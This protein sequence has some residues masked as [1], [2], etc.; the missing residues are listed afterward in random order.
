MSDETDLANGTTESWKTGPD[1]ASVGR[2]PEQTR[3]SILNA[4][5]TEFA[6]RGL[7]GGRTDRIAANAGVAKRMIFH[8]FGS[9][10]GLFQ[11]VLETNYARIRSAEAK[12]ELSSQVPM[13]A[14]AELIEFSFDWFLSHPEFIPLLNEGNLHEGRHVRNSSEVRSLNMPL[15]ERINDILKSGVETGE[16]RPGVDPIELYISIAAISYFYFSNRHTLSGIF[17]RDLMS[18]DALANRR[19]HVVELVLG[20]LRPPMDECSKATTNAG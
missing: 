9:K 14:M 11:A 10:E 3:R 15:V 16:M 17:D 13:K 18:D 1:S 2:N 6:A 12:L 5:T 4:A 20:Y 19:R 7:E 8:Y